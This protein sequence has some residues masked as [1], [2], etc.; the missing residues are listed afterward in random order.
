MDLE[1]FVKSLFRV[2][3]PSDFSYKHDAKHNSKLV[4]SKIWDDAN[5]DELLDELARV[6]NSVKTG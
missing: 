2:S 3:R 1:T 6:I 4:V 5:D